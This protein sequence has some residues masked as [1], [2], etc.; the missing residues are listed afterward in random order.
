MQL[1]ALDQMAAKAF[2]GYLVRKDLVRQFKGQY[3][4]P[5]Y[6]VEF[7]LGRYCASMDR[8][9][10]EEGLQVVERQLWRA[11]R[12]GRRG[13]A[14]Q[15][16]CEGTRLGQNHRPHQGTAGRQDRL[17]CGRAAQ[18]AAQRRSDRRRA[19]QRARAHADRRLLRGGRARPTTPPS[20]RRRSGR[21][22][23]IESLREIQLS[24]RDVL[25]DPVQRPGAVHHR[26]SG[27]SSC[28][29][30]SAWSRRL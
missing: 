29:A 9:E 6:V 7:L 27:R 17:L 12:P 13:R 19:G 26:R 23:G 18:P 5:T 22:F 4:V 2:E 28:S 25:D 30:A 21:P 20:P 8:E 24:K 3:P 1:D 10:I 14:V 16:P 11:S 15:G